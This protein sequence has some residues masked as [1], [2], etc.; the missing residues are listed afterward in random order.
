M[1]NNSLYV[2]T[3]FFIHLSVDGHLSCFHVLSSVNSAI[4][5]IGVRVSF[6]VKIFSG[7][8]PRSG[9]AG[10]YGSL[11]LVFFFF[12]FK[13]SPYHSPQRLCQHSHQ[14]CKGIPFSPHILQD[15]LFVDFFFL[16]DGHS[17]QCKVIPHCSFD[18][19]FSNNE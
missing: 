10:S 13:A 3:S 17:D 1:T 12:F 18:L 4:I 16:D 5:N 2:S 15:L 11:V 6:S 8:M 9:L 14:L 19:H 7:Y